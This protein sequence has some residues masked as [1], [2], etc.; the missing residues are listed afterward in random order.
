ML[1]NYTE[2]YMFNNNLDY[3]L[4]FSYYLMKKEGISRIRKNFQLKVDKITNTE[5]DRS[6]E[7][8]KKNSKKN[9]FQKLFNFYRN[10]RVSQCLCD[11]FNLAQIFD[12]ELITECID[13]TDSFKNCFNC[14]LF[15]GLNYINSVLVLGREKIYIL[16]SVNISKDYILYSAINPIPRTFLGLRQL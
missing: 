12:I 13:D 3:K 9:D 4:Y 14:L 8:I 7:E 6:T 2:T 1:N 15:E 11:M 10:K 5:I 16:T